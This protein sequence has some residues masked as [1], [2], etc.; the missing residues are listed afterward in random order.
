ML[1]IISQY[2][3]Q[4]KPITSNLIYSNQV[5]PTTSPISQKL[6]EVDFALAPVCWEGNSMIGKTIKAP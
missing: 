2:I 4:Q 1:T 5:I 6:K 3:I